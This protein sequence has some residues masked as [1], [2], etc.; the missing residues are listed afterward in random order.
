MYGL[1]NTV[2]GAP[3]TESPDRRR[4]AKSR[5]TGVEFVGACN[6][7]PNRSS[8]YTRA[9]SGFLRHELEHC[10]GIRF[11]AVERGAVEHAVV[12][13][14]SRFRVPAVAVPAETVEYGFLVRCRVDLVDD[15]ATAAA[16]IPLTRK[17]AYAV[18]IIPARDNA[19]KGKT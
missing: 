14:Q 8:P 3:V 19:C 4:R 2:T 7:R 17:A 15:A 9:C 11:P 12:I 13:D 18:K 1:D 5:A 6:S 16:A 10:S